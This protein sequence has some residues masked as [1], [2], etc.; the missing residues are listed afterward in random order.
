MIKG[1]RF[2]VVV[3]GG[4]FAPMPPRSSSEDRP[5]VYMLFRAGMLF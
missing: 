3:D 5:G 4:R 2:S 1:W